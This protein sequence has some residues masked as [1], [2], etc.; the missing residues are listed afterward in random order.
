MEPFSQ[1]RDAFDDVNSGRR[2]KFH[3][4]ERNRRTDRGNDRSQQGYPGAR[5][6]D[7]FPSE[8]RRKRGR[9]DDADE[10][11]N[12]HGSKR[13]YRTN[14]HSTRHSD[15]HHQTPFGNK[16]STSRSE[17]NRRR[18]RHNSRRQKHTNPN[19]ATSN[20]DGQPDPFQFQ[21]HPF[22]N[23]DPEIAFRESLFD[24]MADDEGASFWE[25]VY[26]QPI[27]TYPPYQEGLDGMLYTM[28]DEEYA[29]YVRAKMYEKTHQHVIEERER[30]EKARQRQTHE[31]EE[32]RRHVEQQTR[33]EREVQE[34]LRRGKERKARAAWKDRWQ[35]YLAD[36]ESFKAYLASPN[37]DFNVHGSRRL[38]IQDRIPWPVESGLFDNVSEA[39]VEHFYRRLLI[40]GIPLDADVGLSPAETTALKAERVRW[41]PDKIQH[42]LGGRRLD[43]K[44]LAAVTAIFQVV[45][46]LWGETRR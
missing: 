46:R 29:A 1:V 18:R 33:F 45:D 24:A 15:S 16:E 11:L 8:D 2:S 9:D 22:Q 6:Y 28:T 36:W 39:A 12:P 4:K 34:S 3:F 5:L 32:T 43:Q 19:T 21:C 40:G 37:P 38:S 25:A 31:R 42:R 17:G 7:N 30:R 13:S 44:T 27:H 10:S 26:G 23:M 14:P 41:H 35:R 20:A